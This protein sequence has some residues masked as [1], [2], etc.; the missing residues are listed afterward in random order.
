MASLRTFARVVL[1]GIAVTEGAFALAALAS[2]ARDL[3][4]GGSPRRQAPS[5]ARRRRRSRL[6]RAHPALPRLRLRGP[7]RR[8]QRLPPVQGRPGRR[9]H[10]RTRPR[11]RRR[12]R[13][14]LCL[15][16]ARV[17]RRRRGRRPELRRIAGSPENLFDVSV[18]PWT[19]TAALYPGARWT[20]VR[21]TDQ[22]TLTPVTQ[23]SEGRHGRRARGPPRL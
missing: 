15:V 6:W 11:H 7:V 21:S 3:R 20:A 23:P 12:L 17:R 14:R 13:R 2:P 10:G 22:M 5:T 16:R 8:H 4:P 1:G 19:L 18:Q 9:H